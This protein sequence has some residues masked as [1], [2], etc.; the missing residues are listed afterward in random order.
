MLKLIENRIT[1][2]IKEKYDPNLVKVANK[3]ARSKGASVL[4]SDGTPRSLVVRYVME[5]SDP[6]ESILDFGAGKAAVQTQYLRDNGFINVTAYDFGENITDAHDES[7]LLKQYQTVFASNVLNV[8]S[9]AE[10]L[11]DTISD[12]WSAVK[13]NGRAVFNY[14]ESPRKAGLST[15]EVEQIIQD[16]IGITPVKCAGT[17]RA[18]VWEIYKN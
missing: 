3:T 5:T 17:N 11:R 15:E 6:D 1:K 10:M 4:N 16:E 14:P 18:P 9:T 12:I 7:A 13:P 2:L 8:A